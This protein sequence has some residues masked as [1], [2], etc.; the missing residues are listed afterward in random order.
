[1]KTNIHDIVVMPSRVERTQALAWWVQSLYTDEAEKPVVVGG[2]AMELYAKGAFISADLDFVGN[3]PPTV[4]YKLRE[5]GFER[6]D[7]QWLFEE[8]SV[9]LIFHGESLGSEE[10]AVERIFGDYLV[11]IVS[12]E[13][14]LV[15]R[16]SSWR[17]RQSPNHGMQAY[18]LYYLEHISM[19]IAHLH[20]RA[21]QEDVRPALDSLIRLFFQNNGQLPRA[22][23]LG[24][25]AG[26]EIQS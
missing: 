18:M 22:H 8:E 10:R 23:D 14:L 4:A 17:Y 6:I 20:N 5:A 3:V 26:K 12:A 19:D 21:V 11:L 13:D 1:M 15:D 2:A 9:S 16:L 24:E 25:W 7:R